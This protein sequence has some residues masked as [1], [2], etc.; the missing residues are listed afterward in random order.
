MKKIILLEAITLIGIILVASSASAVEYRTAVENNTYKISSQEEAVSEKLADLIQ[1]FKLSNRH[2][3]I[4]LMIKLL[5]L[6]LLISKKFDRIG[7]IVLIQI[8]KVIRFLFKSI[9]IPITLLIHFI[10][11]S[12][13]FPN[14]HIRLPPNFHHHHHHC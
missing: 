13:L 11:L 12:I 4:S 14:L 7:G 1:N 3:I 10:R 5:I 9:T 6:K 8:L 2:R